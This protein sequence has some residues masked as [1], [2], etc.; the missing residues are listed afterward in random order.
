L[1]IDQLRNLFTLAGVSQPTMTGP[2]P[3]TNVRSITLR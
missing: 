3:W 2:L 1:T